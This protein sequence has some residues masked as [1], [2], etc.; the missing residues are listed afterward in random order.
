MVKWK[1]FGRSKSKDEEAPWEEPTQPESEETM[2]PETEQEE[3]VLAEHTET[4]YSKGTAPKKVA[5][6]QKSSQYPSDQRIWRDVKT[7]EENIDNIHK[8]KSKK[9]PSDLDKTVDRILTKK[10]K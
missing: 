9:A 6:S 4:L 10:K 7:I 3:S 8:T 1:L 5:S 2:E